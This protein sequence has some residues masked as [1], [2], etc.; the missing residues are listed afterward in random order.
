MAS[1]M[2]HHSE[3][4]RA[5]STD[6][7]YLFAK[8]A[9]IRLV[10]CSWVLV[11]ALPIPVGY[12]VMLLLTQAIKLIRLGHTIEA[13]AVAFAFFAGFV[14]AATIVRYGMRWLARRL[15]GGTV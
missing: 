13:L 4:G 12:G 8:N 5:L 7:A 15:A 11:V 14:V 1:V 9:S 3:R 2:Q 6:D 10:I